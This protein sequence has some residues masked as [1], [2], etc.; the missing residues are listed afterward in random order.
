[1]D[2]TIKEARRNELYALL[3]DL[4]P[5]DRPITS[6]TVWTQ[7]RGAYILEK[8]ILDLNGIEPV[9]AYFSRPKELNGSA[10]VLYNHAHGGAYGMGKEEFIRGLEVIQKPPYAEFLASMGMCGLCIDAWVFGE[11]SHATESETFKL[12]LWHGQALWGMMVYDGLRALDYLA[13]RPEVEAS[14]VATLGLSMGSTMSWWL[15][16]LD[17][18]VKACVDICCLTDYQALIDAGGLDLHGIYYYVPSLLKHFTTAGINALIAPRPHLGLAG[19]QD[20]LTPAEGLD[21]IDAELKKA[22]AEEGAPEA[23]RL[24]RVESGHRE[25]K[26]MRREIE[27]FLRKWL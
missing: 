2:S 22:Y 1:M 15:A 10:A 19:N 7:D 14:R 11:R 9:P 4:P 18:R 8:L 21:R 13:S 20:A 6:T 12:M 16:A 25:T 27:A 3:G 24:L 17:E 5:R 23:W 26:E